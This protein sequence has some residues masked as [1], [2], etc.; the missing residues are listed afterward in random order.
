MGKTI[1]VYYSK[2]G[3]TKAAAE[4]I[5]EKTGADICMICVDRSYDSDD[6]KAWD[7]AAK[8][9]KE[10]N[11]PS[12]TSELPDL[13]SYDTVLIGGPV[14]GR[15]VSNAVRVYL[16]QTDF[17]GKKVS[18]FW[19]FYD[20]AENYDQTMKGNV[21]NGTYIGGLPLPRSITGDKT[22]FAAA[23]ESWIKT[24]I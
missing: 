8:E 23:I 13:G 3:N 16:N 9:L 2:D 7:E 6:W 17:T 1:V 20:H 19:T 5:A 4:K 21:K 14:W 24:F 12:I 15:S 18:A 10:E 11:M 22:R